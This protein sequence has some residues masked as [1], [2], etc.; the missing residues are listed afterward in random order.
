[1]LAPGGAV[2][3]D[4]P[5]TCLP[6][7]TEERSEAPRGW[8]EATQV[9]LRPQ[10]GQSKALLSPSEPI[11][12]WEEEEPT[13]VSYSRP[14]EP[15]ARPA[16]SMGQLSPVPRPWVL[17]GQGTETPVGYQGQGRRTLSGKP[18]EEGDSKRGGSL[19]TTQAQ[20]ANHS[21]LPTLS[22]THRGSPAQ[23][24]LSPTFTAPFA[25]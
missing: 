12:L 22:S 19:R 14:Q 20:P 24:L 13:V 7:L 9:G 23:L 8:L 10:H 21:Y 6:Y 5:T 2:S 25:Q 4:K 17:G 1:M 3:G 18:H 16:G 15:R 11:C